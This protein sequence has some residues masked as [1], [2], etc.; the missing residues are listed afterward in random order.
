MHFGSNGTYAYDLEGELLWQV[1]LGDMTTRRGFGEGSS[2]AL[3]KDSLIIN[4]DHEGDSFIVALDKRTGK[5]LWRTERPG[6]VTSWSTPLVVE[7][8]SGTQVIVSS[9]GFSRGYDFETGKE[10]WRLAGMT[11]NSIPTPLHLDGTVFLASGYR[12]NMLQAVD[13]GRAKGDLEG[14]DAV[15]WQ[16]ERDTPTLLRSCCTRISFTS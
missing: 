15:L 11:V 4:W 14:S 7:H 1:D 5:E 6:E 3:H 16:Y 13:L 10:L 12:G 9:T 2:P 8:E